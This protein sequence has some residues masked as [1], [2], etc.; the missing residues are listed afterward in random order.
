MFICDECFIG[1]DYYL[2]IPSSIGPCEICGKTAPCYDVN[3]SR[4]SAE[5]IKKKEE[6]KC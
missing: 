3:R 4:V 2:M 1:K 5:D 6:Q